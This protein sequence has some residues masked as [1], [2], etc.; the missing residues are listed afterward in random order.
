M[1]EG[2]FHSEVLVRE[3]EAKKDLISGNLIPQF[4]KIYYSNLVI[5]LGGLCV[6]YITIII[7]IIIIIT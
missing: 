2:I 5:N 7:I 4:L 1:Q 6:L 3:R